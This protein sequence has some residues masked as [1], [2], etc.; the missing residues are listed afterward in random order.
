M[1]VAL[2]VRGLPVGKCI[3]YKSYKDCDIVRQ[4]VHMSATSQQ[5]YHSKKGPQ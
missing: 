1:M 2:L 3:V 5:H 4:T